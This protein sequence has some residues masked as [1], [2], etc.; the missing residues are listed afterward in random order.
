[1]PEEIIR[2]YLVNP[3]FYGYSSFC[4]GC[5]KHVSAKE[6]FWTETGQ[7]MMDYTRDLQAHGDHG[8]HRMGAI[9]TT[10]MVAGI[11]ALIV[12]LLIA[13]IAWPF[14]GM[15]GGGVVGSCSFPFLMS[16]FG[17]ILINIMGYL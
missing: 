7:N 2:T 17:M 8:S 11:G 4:A 1:M 3:Y 6:L 14:V 9:M 13:L 5:Q 10:A 16:L 12:A 15:K